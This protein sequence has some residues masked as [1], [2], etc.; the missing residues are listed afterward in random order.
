MPFTELR[1]GHKPASLGHRP[2]LSSGRAEPSTV[3]PRSKPKLA[4]MGSGQAGCRGGRGHPPPTVPVL[5]HIWFAKHLR[6][7]RL[8]MG[9]NCCREETQLCTTQHDAPSC[10]TVQAHTT[11]YLLLHTET[12]CIFLNAF[13]FSSRE[14]LIR[15]EKD[16]YDSHMYD[17]CTSEIFNLCYVT[18]MHT[19]YMELYST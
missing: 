14:E 2:M 9:A 16:L 3:Q 17:S 5:V 11:H 19:L 6:K 8:F 4:S 1:Q 7:V 15:V 12:N 10:G 18:T 13:F